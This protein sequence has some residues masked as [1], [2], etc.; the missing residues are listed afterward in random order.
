MHGKG[1]FIVLEGLDGAGKT[2]IARRLVEDLSSRGI[3]ASYTYE[4]TDSEI[5]RLIKSTYNN[6]RDAYIDTLAFAL[7]RLIH[8][9]NWVKPLL[10]KGV[11]V[12]SDRYF[13][14]SVAYQSASGAPFEWVIE[15]NK[16]AVKPDVA[17]YLD[18]EPEEGLSRK[19][20]HISRF[21]EYEEKEF[22]QRVR[23]MYL[24]MVEMGL[25]IYID[26]SKP[27]SEVYGRIWDIVY[28]R[29]ISMNSRVYDT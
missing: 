21:P 16:F 23:S 17:I 3:P 15:V 18:I 4:P 22:L 7:D 28:G 25:L 29:L 24:R 6:L 8:V 9:K 19:Y 14:S 11:T 26:A 12:I 2:T 20:M 1:C 10:D 13:Y 27:L 5:V